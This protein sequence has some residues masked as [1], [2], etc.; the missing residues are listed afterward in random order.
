MTTFCEAMVR[1]FA[2]ASKEW[3][4]ITTLPICLQGNTSSK[5]LQRLMAKIFKYCRR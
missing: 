1:A 4:R 3:R 5:M 2:V